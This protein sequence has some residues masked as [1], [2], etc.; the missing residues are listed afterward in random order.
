MISRS[1]RVQLANVE[2]GRAEQLVQTN[3]TP[4]E[5]VD[6]LRATLHVAEE[7][8]AQ[9]ELDHRVAQLELARSQALLAQRTI[10]SPIDGV[11]VK[12]NLGPGEYVH[13]DTF[14]VELAAV[15]PLFVEAYPPVRYFALLKVGD[16]GMVTSTETGGPP[17]AA[18]VQVIDPVFDAAS[19]TFGVRLIL[20]NPNDAVPAGLRCRV[21]FNVPDLPAAPTAAVAARP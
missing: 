11:V 10:R 18:T 9:A 8:L 20:N 15:S 3:A 12:R 19:G 13:Q 6:E 17:Y 21:A 14:I 4:R 5:K 1:V 16:K 2:L 7:D